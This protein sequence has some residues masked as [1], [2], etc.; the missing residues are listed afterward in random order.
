MSILSVTQGD[1]SRMPA[2]ADAQPTQA[3]E[4]A[5]QEKKN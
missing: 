1:G 2:P 4:S 5:Q 3:E